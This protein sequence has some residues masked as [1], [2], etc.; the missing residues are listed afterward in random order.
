MA[1]AAPN[2]PKS[3]SHTAK[4]FIVSFLILF[5]ELA[6]IRWIS[7]EIRIFAYI[8]NLILLA[9]FLGVG[10]GCYY[11]ARPVRPALTLTG[12]ALLLLMGT[13]QLFKNT[14]MPLSALSDE[15][16][17]FSSQRHAGFL[18]IAAGL[19]ATGMVFACVVMTLF[20]LGQLLGQLFSASRNRLGAYSIN[21]AA[22][23]VG[24][25]TFS[26]LAF[27]YLPPWVWFALT[28]ACLVPLMLWDAANFR[29]LAGTVV[30]LLLMALYPIA[31]GQ[32]TVWSPY[33][34]L[35]VTPITNSPTR[36][37]TI[38]VNDVNS[39]LLM[40][41]SD[42]AVDQ[43]AD[44]Q[45]KQLRPYGPYDI[46]YRF[47]PD[48]KDVLVVGAGSGNDV[49]A[50]LR[51]GATHVTAVEID[52]GIYRLASRWHPER[53]YADPRVDIVIDD[54][55]SFF[56]HATRRYDLIVFGLLD[57]HTL[58][59][60]L[61]NTRIDHYVYTQESLREVRALLA[62]GGVVVITFETPRVWVRERLAALLAQ[63]FAHEPYV[64]ENRLHPALGLGGEMFVDGI[65]ITELKP[66]VDA[67]PTLSKFVEAHRLPTMAGHPVRLTSDDWPYL[68]LKTPHV[69]PLH[70]LVS[71]VL[72]L[73]FVGFRRLLM[74]GR[75]QIDWHFFFLGAAFLL[76]EFQNISKMTLLFGATW[77]VN[78]LTI[79]AILV[80]ILIANAVV[81]AWKGIAVPVVYGA[82]FASVL[83]TL[84]MP[85]SSFNSLPTVP[86]AFAAGGLLNLPIGF[87]GIIFADSFRRSPDPDAALGSNLLGAGLGG[88]LESLSFVTGISALLLLVGVLYVV[89]WRFRKSAA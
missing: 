56:K 35:Q 57:S 5:L 60:A 67:D 25:W 78:A 70:V 77:L 59:S 21:V 62:P 17:W 88:M 27:T 13:S 41:L 34:R 32:L 23:I 46:P 54:A 85:M 8:N 61:T 73:V 75:D 36:R 82:L 58:G 42:A 26:A 7:T 4:L 74:P 79:T 81:V 33:Q 87:A 64:F 22:G 14:L 15:V 2:V 1:S 71:I 84:L 29:W 47:K 50:A 80:L 3:P 9:C 53:P 24:M 55:R 66:T 30:A 19:V 86:R 44:P 16:A 83:L 51:N 89:S 63:T 11:A 38:S 52:P 49:A 72:L 76:L 48:A 40:D 39:M 31:V 28:I 37:Y 45:V 12:L 10:L 43:I 65:N 68:Y 20:P 6:L 18:Q 69:P